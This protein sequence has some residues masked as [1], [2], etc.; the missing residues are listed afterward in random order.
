[1]MYIYI[2]LFMILYHKQKKLIDLKSLT[3][4][5]FFLSLNKLNTN[6]WFKFVYNNAMNNGDDIFGGNRS[7]LRVCRTSGGTQPE[8]RRKH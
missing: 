7:L 1:M 3:K 2:I 8:R 6:E 5:I 4:K